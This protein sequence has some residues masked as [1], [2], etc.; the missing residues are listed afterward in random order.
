MGLAHLRWGCAKVRLECAFLGKLHRVEFEGSFARIGSDPRCEICIPGLPAPVCVYLQIGTSYLAAIELIENDPP[1]ACEPVFA[2]PG[3]TVWIQP[4]ARITVESI[5][6][7]GAQVDEPESFSWENFNVE[8][9]RVFPNTLVARSG[10][11]TNQDRPPHL[12]L[13]STISVLGTASSCH[14]RANHK[15]ISKYQ[16][17]IFRGEQQGESCRVID[18]FGE[19]PTLVGNATADGQVLEVGGKLQIANLTFEAVRFLYN[20]SR[21]GQVV[22]VRSQFTSLPLPQQ[23]KEQISEPRA[24]SVAKSIDSVK[25]RLVRAIGFDS[26]K[27]SKSGVHFPLDAPKEDLPRD[28]PGKTQAVEPELIAGLERVAIS[29]ERIAAEFVKLTSRLEIVEKSLISIPEILEQNS[30]QLIETVDSLRGIVEKNATRDIAPNS[31]GHDE[32][33]KGPL[34]KQSSQTISKTPP[35]SPKPE[36]PRDRSNLKPS[37]GF[38]KPDKKQATT[39]VAKTLPVGSQEQ[40]DRSRQDSWFSRTGDTLSSW[41]PGNARRRR[42]IAERENNSDPLNLGSQSTALRKRLQQHDD[43]SELLAASESED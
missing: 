34:P 42:E 26:G 32:P 17:I 35:K 28:T 16:A 11:F 30:Q 40:K 43:E 3:A 21:P 20:A 1:S 22:E 5:E 12:R 10:F 23:S 19:H 7:S 9:V 31:F 39:P 33:K 29:Q 15:R 14:L 25:D 27:T 4:N 37:K 24:S 41:I 8:D 6:P 36:D 18:L 38:Q 13:L 2:L